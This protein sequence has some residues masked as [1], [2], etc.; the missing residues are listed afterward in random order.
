MATLFEAHN[1]R[2]QR[3][4]GG[5]FTGRDIKQMIQSWE[6]LREELKALF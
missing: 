4:Q 5:T 2:Q 1:V 6:L 3:Y